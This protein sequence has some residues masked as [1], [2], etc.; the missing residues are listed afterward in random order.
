MRFK[1]TT[2]GQVAL[3]LAILVT[4]WLLRGSVGLFGALFGIVVVVLFF[5]STKVIIGPI[6]SMSPAM[7]QAFALLFYFTK[8]AALAALLIVMT[9]QADVREYL[10]FGAIAVALIVGSIG[11]IVA[12][13]IEHT[14]ERILTYDLPETGKTD[15]D[16]IAE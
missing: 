11:W 10:D 16:T 9:S 2:Y 14:R 1:A 7:S 4:A 13:T 3:W 12:Q 5:G 6:A 15:T 8:A